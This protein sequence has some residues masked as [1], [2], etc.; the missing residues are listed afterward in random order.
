MNY[1]LKIK[2]FFMQIVSYSSSFFRVVD[3]FQALITTRISIIRI[4]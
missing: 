1:K 4:R 3:I 2:W